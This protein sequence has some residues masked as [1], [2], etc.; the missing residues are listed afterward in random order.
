MPAPSVELRASYSEGCFLQMSLVV[1]RD[2][3]RRP[4]WHFKIFVAKHKNHP[5]EHLPL[6]P[7]SPS[8]S[9]SLV[10]LPGWQVASFAVAEIFQDT[11][12]GNERCHQRSRQ[13]MGQY[14]RLMLMFS[15]KFS[16]CA[17]NRIPAPP[18]PSLLSSYSHKAERLR[19]K[20]VK[21]LS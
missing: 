15:Q 7:L 8:S 19:A 2:K 16:H 3:R 12:H 1:Q 18:L 4:V 13:I 6:A 5:W 11:E 14:F 21:L 17:S 10:M 20:S 9:S